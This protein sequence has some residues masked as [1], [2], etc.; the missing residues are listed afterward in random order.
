MYKI[1][2]YVI[3]VIIASEWIDNLVISTL[4]PSCLERKKAT[5]GLYRTQLLA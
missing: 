2:I 1:T 4:R 5:Y 3:Y